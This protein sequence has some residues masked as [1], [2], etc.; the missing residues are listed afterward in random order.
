VQKFTDSLDELKQGIQS[1]SGELV[2]A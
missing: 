2:S 1:K